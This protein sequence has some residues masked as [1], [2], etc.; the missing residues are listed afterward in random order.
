MV[1]AFLIPVGCLQEWIVHID[2]V[3]FEEI[4]QKSLYRANLRS[5]PVETKIG[6]V[7]GNCTSVSRV[8]SWI[9][10]CVVFSDVS[11]AST[12]IMCCVADLSRSRELFCGVE[13][14]GRAYRGLDI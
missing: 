14:F 13:V 6:P 4:S 7:S 12:S 11:C 1:S 5:I 3:L 10:T 2:V 9:R 8:V